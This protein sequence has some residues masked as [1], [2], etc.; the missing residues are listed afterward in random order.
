[1]SIFYAREYIR[2]GQV[3]SGKRVVGMNVVGILGIESVMCRKVGDRGFLPAL[4]ES[5]LGMFMSRYS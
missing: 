5:V 3:T 4:V 2:K 1:M